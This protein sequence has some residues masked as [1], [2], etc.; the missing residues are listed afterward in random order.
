M[1]HTIKFK[2]VKNTVFASGNEMCWAVPCERTRDLSYKLR[3]G[4]ICN[5]LTASSII[6]CY[7]ALIMLPRRKRDKIISAMRKV[8]EDD[9]RNGPVSE[10]DRKSGRKV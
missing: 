7:E 2:R 3:Y 8:I 10:T 5:T 1:K 6:D 9:R 4:Y